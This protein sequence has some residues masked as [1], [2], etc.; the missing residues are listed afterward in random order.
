MGEVEV[1]GVRPDEAMAFVRSVRVPFLD[2]ATGGADE[3][4]SMQRWAGAIETDRAWVAEDAGRFVA[5]CAIYTMDVSV[6]AGPG[7]DCPLV[8]MGGVSAVGVHPT[9]RRRGL[10]TEMMRRMLDDGRRRGEP[11]S[12]LH[13]SESSIYGRFGFGL[14]TESLSFRIESRRAA[15]ARPAPIPRLQLVDRLEAAKTVAEFHDRHRRTRPGEVVMGTSRWEE[16]LIDDSPDGGK[17]GRGL[18]VAAGDDGYVVYRATS[19]EVDEL[20]VLDLRGSTPEVEAGL[21][22]YLFEIDLVD[23]VTARDRPVDDPVRWRL[24]DPRRLEVTSRRD[25][26]YLRVLDFAAAFEARGYPGE[27]RLV[28]DVVAPPLD[29]GADDP[30]PG[31]WVLDAGPD[32]CSCRR[33]A[34]GEEADLRLDVTALGTLYMGGFAASTLAAAGA[35]EELRPGRLTVADRLLTT[36][37]APLTVT[38]F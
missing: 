13:A 14:A 21:W 35:V 16:L 5:N 28:L 29:G 9:H 6:P 20:A 36:T 18:F 11:L 30:V 23:V 8:P 26:L 38:N 25:R 1:R 19:G 15:M 37:P 3:E 22:R 7:G 34:A 4:A 27:G 12:G 10:L 17:G 32:G 24:A 33:A 31:R 2:P